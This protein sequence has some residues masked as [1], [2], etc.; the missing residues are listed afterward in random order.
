MNPMDRPLEI[1]C[2]VDGMGIYT[3]ITNIQSLEQTYT[4]NNAV[5]GMQQVGFEKINYM[6]ELTGNA[7]REFGHRRQCYATHNRWVWMRKRYRHVRIIAFDCL[8]L[9]VVKYIG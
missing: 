3:Y 6:T 7:C 1:S 2:I 9:K 4:L 8:C 5:I